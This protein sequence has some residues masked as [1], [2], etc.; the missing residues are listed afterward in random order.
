TKGS[1]DTL[2]T[3]L[4][5]VLLLSV[6]ANRMVA[7]R[8]PLPNWYGLAW[9]LTLLFA[10]SF[11]TIL[12]ALCVLALFLADSRRQAIRDVVLTGVLAAFVLL[13]W[14]VRNY[15]ELQISNNDLSHPLFDD[16]I[17]PVGPYANHPF[18]DPN[19][20]RKIAQMGEIAYFNSRKTQATEWMRTHPSRFIQ[21]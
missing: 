19:Q 8:A 11:V 3:S 21:L 16:N 7:R 17:G 13:P 1:Y 4:F 18:R 10:P 20:A 9:G 12:A 15:L 5:L 6:F 2:L 14:T